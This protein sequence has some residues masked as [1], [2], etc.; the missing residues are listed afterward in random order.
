MIRYTFREGD[1]LRIKAAKQADP[2]VIGETIAAVCAKNGGQMIPQ[3]VVDEA[4]RK[5]SPLH[6]F[7][8]WDVQTAAE[9]H[10]L[11]TARSLIRI[12]RVHDDDAEEGTS[13]AFVSISTKAG[14]AYRTVGEVKTSVDLQLAVLLQ[15]ERD[16]HAFERR[17][18]EL[19]DICEGV[20]ALREKVAHKASKLENRVAA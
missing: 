6:K 18:R 9:A 13:R 7:F 8:E 12:V 3:K 16:L 2:Q 17:Y 10:W 4:K 14:T 11:D 19:S 20:K 15:A 1:P 5:Q